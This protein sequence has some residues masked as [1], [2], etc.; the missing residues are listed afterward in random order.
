LEIGFI[1]LGR[2]GQAMARSLLAAGHELAVHDWIAADV[3]GLEQLGARVAP[4][5]AE[6]CNADA[7]ITMLASEE[8]IETAVFGHAGVLEA[9]PAGA[10]HLTMSG[11]SAE[12]GRRLALAHRRAGQFFVAAPVLGSLEAAAEGQLFILAAGGSAAVARCRPLF[13]ALAQRSFLLGAE[14]ATACQLHRRLQKKI[15]KRD[16]ALETTALGRLIETEVES[17]RKR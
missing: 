7:V 13:A 1:G 2:M 8:D 16:D 10:T 9:M 6:V 11:I 14:H 5:I 3:E 4:R 15:A 17:H 12:L